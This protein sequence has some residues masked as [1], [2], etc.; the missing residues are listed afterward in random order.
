MKLI[1]FLI[2]FAFLN[3]NLYSEKILIERGDL[4]RLEKTTSECIVIAA[5]KGLAVEAAKKSDNEIYIKLTL[6]KGLKYFDDIEYETV[7]HVQSTVDRVTVKNNRIEITLKDNKSELEKFHFKEYVYG[8]ATGVVAIVLYV[9]F[10]KATF[11]V[12]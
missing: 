6:A 1:A 3:S 12:N 2:L 9:F 8:I 4:M 10:N 5:S 11:K 7:V